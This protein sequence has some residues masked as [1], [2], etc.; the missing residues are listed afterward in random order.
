MSVLPK[1]ADAVATPVEQGKA[2]P[3][4]E[5]ELLARI[6]ELEADREAHAEA[7]KAVERTAEEY[8]KELT[9]IVELAEALRESESQVAALTAE[10][11]QPHE[12]KP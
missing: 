5:K 12:T 4:R 3:S 9:E 7:L 2:D 6:A 1:S 11:A 10:I 8:R